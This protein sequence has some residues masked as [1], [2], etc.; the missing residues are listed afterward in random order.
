MFRVNHAEYYISINPHY[1]THINEEHIN[2][3][4]LS[5]NKKLVL[6]PKKTTID[7]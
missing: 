7:E 2:F 6:L 3:R 5:E 4:V 1:N